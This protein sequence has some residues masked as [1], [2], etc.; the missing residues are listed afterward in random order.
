[1]DKWL[2]EEGEIMAPGADVWWVIMIILEIGVP[3]A[4]LVL[5]AVLVVT[6][7]KILRIV[8]RDNNATDDD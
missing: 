4:V 1:M 7:R 3:I 5:L 2:V 6:S 8:G